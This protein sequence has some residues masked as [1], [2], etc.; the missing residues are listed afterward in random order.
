MLLLLLS[1]LQSPIPCPDAPIQTADCL[2]QLK[3]FFAEYEPQDVSIA[4]QPI[5]RFMIKKLAARQE[6][7]KGRGFA[8]I[9][10][11]SHEMQEKACAEKNGAEFLGREIAVKVA[12][13]SPDKVGN[14]EAA[15]ADENVENAVVEQ[16]AEAAPAA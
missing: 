16:A 4:L 13:D 3:K 6:R 11:S 2:E 14:K 8:F 7:R 10:L 5:P 9:T 15:S 1:L 12:I